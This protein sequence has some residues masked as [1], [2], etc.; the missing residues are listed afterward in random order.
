MCSGYLSVTP[1]SFL[2][3]RGTSDGA[4]HP[5]PRERDKDAEQPTPTETHRLRTVKGNRWP[6]KCARGC[7]QKIPRDPEIRFVVDFGAPKPYPAYLRAHSPDYP[8]RKPS[9]RK[10]RPGDTCPGF[11]PASLL[12]ESSKEAGETDSSAAESFVPEDPAHTD[13]ASF[14]SPQAGRAWASGQLVFNAGSFESARSGFADY[15]KDGE[16][17]EQL[18]TRVNRVILQDLEQKVIALRALHEKLRDQ[19]AGPSFGDFVARARPV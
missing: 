6:R 17:G 12:L 2:R 8:G 14:P 15:A 5:V 18:R 10:A 1:R 9:E 7:D 19:F 11:V 4:I 16:T 3:H 13:E